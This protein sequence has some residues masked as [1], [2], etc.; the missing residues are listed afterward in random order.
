MKNILFIVPSLRRAGAETQIIDLVNHV[1]HKRY[2]IHL[3]S[4]SQI[5]DQ[6]ERIDKSRVTYHHVL[7]KH[8]FYLGFLPAISKIINDNEIDLIHCTMQFSLLVALLAM[9]I[10]K[11]SPVLIVVI[12]TTVNRG[13]K[14]DIHDKLIYQWLMRL[15][16]KIIFVCNNQRMF[17]EGNYPFI[18]QKSS[19]IYNG[20]DEYYFLPESWV[21][22]GI[23]LRKKLGI[24]EHACVISCIAGFRKEK[25]HH[26][27]IDALSRSKGDIYLIL[28]GDGELRS[29]IEKLVN[30]K[31][32]SGKVFFMGVVNEV[33]PVFSASDATILA[34]TAV[35]TFSI[36]MLESMA[37]ATP[38]IASDIG[39]M[40]E[41]IENGN[42]GWLIT[43]GNVKQLSVVM[44][45]IASDL[46]LAK[47]IGQ[48]ARNKVVSQ[49]SITSMA[50]QTSEIF[51]DLMAVK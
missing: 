50:D 37:M 42:T 41:A 23:E 22:S 39:G 40:S 27:L 8:K 30:D 20:V 19:V 5:Q 33:R 28:A 26:L 7:R 11:R 32:L 14:E 16:K 2:N 29:E 43:P 21:S 13:I 9:M 36:A 12:H 46:S 34:S 17:W 35:E 4:F 49:F 24:P 25:G 18:K 15:C 6:L 44:S 45:L 10:S 47:K 48:Q 1:D 3:L 38:M 31:G 51:D